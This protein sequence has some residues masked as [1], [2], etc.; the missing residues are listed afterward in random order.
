MP[1]PVK[2][3]KEVKKIGEEILSQFCDLFVEVIKVN[4]VIKVKKHNG[5]PSKTGLC[6]MI[7]IKAEKRVVLTA[8]SATGNGG[9]RH[10]NPVARIQNVWWPRNP[11]N[12][13]SAIS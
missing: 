1:F 4:Y 2:T 10:S 12:N 5:L 3:K 13:T 11:Y 6:W 7:I 8:T 9:R